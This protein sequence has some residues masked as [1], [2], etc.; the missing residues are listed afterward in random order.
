[1]FNTVNRFLI[2]DVATII[3]NILM[4]RS[5]IILAFILLCSV[6]SWS[7][8]P[9]VWKS[10][11]IYQAIE[12]LNF[13]GSVLY[14]AAHP[15]DEN[16]RLISYFA[17]HVKARTAYLSLTRGDGGQ[18]L[19][20]PEIRELLG[21]IR[22][23]ELLAARRL[24]GGE[25]MFSRANDFGYSKNPEETLKIWDRDEVLSDVVW[26]IRNFKPDVIINRFEHNPERSTHG[27]HTASAILSYE[28]F[29]LSGRPDV[30]SDQLSKVDPHQSRRLF[31]NTGWWF[32]GSRQAFEKADK[33]DFIT[34]DIGTYYPII[35]KSN[36]E[37]AAESRSQHKCQGMGNT[38][39]RGTS[40]EYIK[41]L[42]GDMPTSSSDVF[43]G[44]NTTWSR[45]DG[46]AHIGP[47]VSAVINNFSFT[48]PSASV[49]D[50]VKIYAEIK[51]LEEGYWKTVKIDEV[52]NIIQACMGLYMEATTNEHTYAPGS[53]ISIRFEVTNRSSISATVDQISIEGTSI[54]TT[55]NEELTFNNPLIFSESTMINKGVP[56]TAPYWL[57]EAGSLGMYKVDD[58]NLIGNPET[59]RSIKAH[60]KLTIDGQAIDYTQ[61]VPYKYNSPEDGPVYRPLEITPEL[62][63]STSDKVYIFNKGQSKDVVV[64]V[65]SAAAA[66]SGKLLLPLPKGWKST[67]EYYEFNV[68]QKGAEQT[69]TF[70]VT[71]PAQQSEIFIAPVV[72][73]NGKTYNKEMISID[74]D[75]I[76]FQSVLG[77]A[78]A[79]L[80]NIDIDISGPYIAYI[81]GAGDE[82]PKSLEQVGYQVE[83]LTVDEISVERLSRYNAVVMGVRAYNKWENIRFKQPELLEY[84]NKGG[85]LVIQYNTSRRI[86]TDQLGP[87]PLSVSRE[88]VTVEEAPVTILAPQHPVMTTPNKITSAD[89]DGWVQE[90]GLYFPNEWDEKY[91]PILASNDPGEDPLK[92]GLLV[93][94]YGEGWYVYTGY[95]WFRELPAGVPGA[96]RIFAN[97]LSLGNTV[98]P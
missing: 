1:V 84:V 72:E 97:M 45:V 87:Y 16:T 69:F 92:G 41:L 23:Q 37:I 95:S 60:F 9:K 50:L 7:Q 13:L 24:D 54:D 76:P 73:A 67:P 90:R 55:L 79:K 78:R 19:I 2:I 47:M 57:T 51:K 4:K 98:R 82:I 20:G 53:E 12:K 80:V 93:A 59:E 28:A 27:H 25:Q 8:A 52:K 43:E 86:R 18:N 31:M 89:F 77:E 35:G 5:T 34:M 70:E 14:V 58:Q 11:D 17:N 49:P 71:P 83:E 75:H 65:K 39:S 36:S 94:P 61:D 46:G 48:D 26:A 74:Y 96:Y 85:T 15:D 21:M 91:T 33:S 62:F 42:K 38:G 22:T 6:S 40:L 64:K 30:Y 44:I 81:Q 66:Q 56:L 68:E 10:G 29:D 63:V 32:Y 3:D 88:R